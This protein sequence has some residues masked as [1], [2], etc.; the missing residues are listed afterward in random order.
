MIPVLFRSL[1]HKQ[2]KA[3]IRSSL[4]LKEKYLPTG[5]FEKLKA[6]L[7][8]LGNMQDLS[9]YSSAEVLSIVLQL[10]YYCYCQ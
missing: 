7:V 8:A 3:I 1:T 6:R 2:R 9:L 10:L 5:E 4:F